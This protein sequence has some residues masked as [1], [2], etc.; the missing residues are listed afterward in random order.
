MPSFASCPQTSSQTILGRFTSS[1]RTDGQVNYRALFDCL[2]YSLS[3]FL[4]IMQI[5]LTV[6]QLR[7]FSLSTVKFTN[8]P[9]TVH[10]RSTNRP[11]RVHKLSTH[12]SQ[13][14]FKRTI[15]GV[16]SKVDLTAN[17]FSA[18]HAMVFS[19]LMG[20]QSASFAQLS[21]VMNYLSQDVRRPY[22]RTCV[23]RKDADQPAHLRSLIRIFTESIL[24]SQGCKVSSRGQQKF[25]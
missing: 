17:D 1:P 6:Q 8:Y 14:F 9:R 23:P 11:R 12:G 5:F 7:S 21:F 18:V 4:R 3:T 15:T 2:S 10:K 13:T 16:S 24:D 22:I 19:L 25:L 20:I